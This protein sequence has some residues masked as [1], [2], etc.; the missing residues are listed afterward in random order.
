M[1][2]KVGRGH[3]GSPARAAVGREEREGVHEAKQ[4]GAE[5]REGGRLTRPAA[6]LLPGTPPRLRRPH[7][8]TP[9]RLPFAAT[10]AAHVPPA[11]AAAHAGWAGQPQLPHFTPLE[12]MMDPIAWPQAAQTFRQRHVLATKAWVWAAGKTAP[13]RPYAT[14]PTRRAG[15]FVVAAAAAAAAMAVPVAVDAAGAAPAAAALSSPSPAPA[16]GHGPA[17][18]EGARGDCGALPPPP[19]P[20]PPPLTAPP[21]SHPPA[22]DV[23]GR[24][25]TS[26]LRGDPGEAQVVVAACWRR[27]GEPARVGLPET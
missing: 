6:A 17:A 26:P 27:P 22:I 8:R 1:S 20:P 15:P 12:P 21:P 5:R 3:L 13:S 14:P 10:N 7:R 4:R 2:E 23:G 25:F 18:A 16:D 24:P 19:P 9:H 11:K